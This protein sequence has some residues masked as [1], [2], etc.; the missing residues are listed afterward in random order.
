MELKAIFNS[1]IISSSGHHHH[2]ITPNN[3]KKEGNRNIWKFQCEQKIKRTKSKPLSL[4]GWPSDSIAFLLCLPCSAAILYL[5]S[6]V[7]SHDRQ[8]SQQQHAMCCANVQIVIIMH[9]AAA[10]SR[11][12]QPKQVCCLLRFGTTKRSSYH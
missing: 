1:I 3:H 5:L 8:Q 2:L 6:A 10:D 9:Q 7:T 11:E 4:I 12:V